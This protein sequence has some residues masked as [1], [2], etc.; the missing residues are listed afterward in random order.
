MPDYFGVYR[1]VCHNNADPLRQGRITVRIPAL[2]GE[3]ET[4][5][6]LPLSNSPLPAPGRGVWIMFEAG[7]AS[8]PGWLSGFQP[9]G[10]HAQDVVYSN[11]TSGL[12]GTNVQ[13]AIDELAAL[14]AHLQSEIDAINAEIATIDSEITTL[15]GEV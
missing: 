13:A 7:K 4:D 3:E 1:G 15:E 9:W 11:T 6:A 10:D 12:P 2:F 8:H 5:W 14:C